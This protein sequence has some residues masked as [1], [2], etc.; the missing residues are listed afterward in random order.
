MIGAGDTEQ[1]EIIIK[2]CKFLGNFSYPL[3][4]T[5]IPLIYCLYTWEN[6]HENDS[7][8]NKIC[9]SVGS[10][11]IMIFNS[12]ALIKLYEE[13]V[14]KWLTEKYLIKKNN[15]KEKNKNNEA[16]IEHTNEIFKETEENIKDF[17]DEN[18]NNKLLE[19]NNNE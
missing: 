3:Y 12:Y 5:H 15:E 2:I 4:I 10:F 17:G 18:K 6:F 14:R 7:L 1:N 19:E 9:V 16:N 11:F 13:P 8:F